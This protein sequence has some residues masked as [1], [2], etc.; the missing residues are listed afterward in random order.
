M[1]GPAFL[2]LLKEF[3]DMQ[4]SGNPVRMIETNAMLVIAIAKLDWI[5]A[6]ESVPRKSICIN[7]IYGFPHYSLTKG[8]VLDFAIERR[9]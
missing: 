2:L 5:L 9:C 4:T 8:L 7:E 1:E 3:T 6:I